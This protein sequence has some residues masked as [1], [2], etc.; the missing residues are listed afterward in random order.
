MIDKRN[1][2][3]Y[4]SAIEDEQVNVLKD[5]VRY[6]PSIAL[7]CVREELPWLKEVLDEG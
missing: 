5:R 7:L 1:E 3:G 6:S 4:N 2:A